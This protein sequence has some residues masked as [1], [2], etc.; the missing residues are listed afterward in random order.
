[1]FYPERTIDAMHERRAFTLVEALVALAIIALLLGV[2]TPALSSARD[3]TRETVCAATQ[4]ELFIGVAAWSVEHR[5]TIPGV[6][7]TGHFALGDVFA[8]QDMCYDSRPSTPTSVFDWMSPVFGD[9][10]QLSANRAERTRQLFTRFACPSARQH[11]DTLWGWAPDIGQFEEILRDEGFPQ[12]SYLSPASFH[13]L[14]PRV[15]GAT[16]GMHYGWIGPVV[17]PSSY[18]PQL[19]MVGVQPSRKVFLADGTRYV[20]AGGLLD[21]DVDVSPEYFGSF[22][23][24]GPIYIASTAYGR[25]RHLAPPSERAGRPPVDAGAPQHN[26]DLSYRHRGRIGT[27]RFDGSFVWMTEDESKSDAAPWYPSGSEF[28]GFRATPSATE[29]HAEGDILF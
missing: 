9:S 8:Q 15:G 23:S 22:T 12:I 27:A 26:R 1:M 24:S 11:N 5:D 28:T 20:G 17:T 16:L 21:F 3:I 14:G 19:D 29:R 13:L 10:S 4:G 6:N 2:L 18:R 25:S 7:T